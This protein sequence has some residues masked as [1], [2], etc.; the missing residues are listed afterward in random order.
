[1]T[2]FGIDLGQAHPAAAGTTD[3]RTANAL[4]QLSGGLPTSYDGNGNLYGDGTRAYAYDSEGA[5]RMLAA[6][7][8]AG[9]GSAT[10]R[11]DP[12]ARR[13]PKTVNGVTTLYQHD[14]AGNE[15]AEF[16]GATNALLKVVSST[17]LSR[18][19]RNLVRHL[20]SRYGFIM[21]SQMPW[22]SAFK[23]GIAA[24]GAGDLPAALKLC[25]VAAEKADDPGPARLL[26]VLLA[27][28]GQ[29]KDALTWA[30]HAIALDL[31]SAPSH[32]ALGRVLVQ[33]GQTIE[34]ERAFRAALAID[35]TLNAARQGVTALGDMRHRTGLALFQAKQWA[36]AAQV[37]TEAARL[38]P[39]RADI[40]HD[41][42]TA[43]HEAGDLTAAQA[44]YEAALQYEPARAETWHNLGSLRQMLHDIGGALAAYGNAFRL[45][46]DF[47]PRI[48][49]ELAAGPA[50]RV[51]LRAADLRATLAHAGDEAGHNE[52]DRERNNGG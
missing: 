32:A 42:G 6:G 47:F 15:F 43:H 34:A 37:L 10:Y 7:G 48:A 44:S 8:L 50:G 1:M 11:Y 49:Q 41:L 19:K 24:Y 25:R 38:L 46:P 33:D 23:R 40:L 9:G 51:W 18:T 20:K 21:S 16:D 12:F 28:A 13:Y 3:S 30:R 2:V 52:S 26:A 35:P 17:A 27:E 4:G 39:R 31:I 29:T 22:I 45:R 5:G 36:R 14:L